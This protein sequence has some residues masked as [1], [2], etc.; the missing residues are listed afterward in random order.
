MDT[1]TR[2]ALL[3]ALAALAGAGCAPAVSRA[4][5]TA[6]PFVYVASGGDGTIT[7]LDAG[8]GRQVGAAVSAG[9]APRQVAA[10]RAGTDDRLV[11][12]RTDGDGASALAL[13]APES[14]EWVAQPIVVEP[15]ARPSLVRSDG[16]RLAAVVYAPRPVGQSAARPACRIALVDLRRGAVTGTH[17]LCAGDDA[18]R[19][20][21]LGQSPW[22]P[23]VYAAVWAG[24]RLVDGRWSAGVGR[25]VALQAET[26]RR[27]GGYSL[28][29]VPGQVHFW[30]GH[31]AHDR[32]LYVLESFSGSGTADGQTEHAAG[33]ERRW[34]L[35]RLDPATLTPE[36]VYPLP[37]PPQPQARFAVAPE[38]G[39]AYVLAGHD[40]GS[41]GAALLQ[42]DLV[43]GSASRY[44]ALPGAGVELAVTER[45]IFVTNPGGGGIWVIDRR[46]RRIVRAVPVGKRPLA[47]AAAW[48]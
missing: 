27:I 11:V 45:S 17:D 44:V 3:L 19:D 24:P 23:A 43:S 12:L 38:G 10:G 37:H 39:Q 6:P 9:G 2:V 4:A 40:A 5:A 1:G 29:G 26:G 8:S 35:L 47:V 14:N 7:R 36:A 25:I 33:G 16:R 15:G 42:V 48:P 41:G 21:A 30:Q 13:V 32:A 22:G 46:E 31:A 28:D 20:L 34:Q 18:V